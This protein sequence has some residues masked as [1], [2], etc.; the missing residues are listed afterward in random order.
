[1]FLIFLLRKEVDYP[2]ILFFFFF[3]S[4]PF[5]D[6]VLPFFSAVHS[7]V[8]FSLPFSLLMFLFCIL[9]LPHSSFSLLELS[10][11]L[12]IF[13]I[14]TMHHLGSRKG[15]VIFLNNYSMNWKI[16]SHNKK[17]QR[18]QYTF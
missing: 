6:K 17:A 10:F 1:M 2:A 18:M 8:L 16:E 12:Y 14:S 9:T 5:K 7:L 15:N 3:H 11:I 4:T 13:L